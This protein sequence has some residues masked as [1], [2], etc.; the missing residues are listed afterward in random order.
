[1]DFNFNVSTLTLTEKKEILQTLL[2]LDDYSKISNKEFSKRVA[3]MIDF[4]QDA[5]S[6]E[7]IEKGI[8]LL[9]LFLKTDL[10][11]YQKAES[12]YFLGNAFSVKKTL[13]SNETGIASPWNNHDIEKQIL[14]YRLALKYNSIALKNCNGTTNGGKKLS[15]TRYCQICTNLGNLMDHIGRFI[16]GI[17]YRNAALSQNKKFGMAH[18]CKGIS[19]LYYSQYLD[20]KNDQAIFRHSAYQL[21]QTALMSEI[22]YD[23]SGSIQNA[24]KYIE[25]RVKNKNILTQKLDLLPFSSD[26]S[27]DETKYQAWCL[28]NRLYLNSLNELG[29]IKIAAE[30]NLAIPCGEMRVDDGINCH[31]LFNQ[32]K[33]D[34][35]VARYL[36]Y[37]GITGKSEDFVEKNVIYSET[38]DVPVYSI[39]S[40]K[41]KVSFRLAYSILDKIAFFLNYYLKLGVKER[42][43]NFRTLWYSQNKRKGD[44][45]TI[46]IR[47]DLLNKK[48]NLALLGLFWLS[49]DLYEKDSGFI[50]A[51]EPDAKEWYE[52]RN[53]LEH[54]FLKMTYFDPKG[55]SLYSLIDQINS[56]LMYSIPIDD[57]Q[58]KTIKLLK[59]VRAGIIY[60]MLAIS[61]EE[62]KRKTTF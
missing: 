53:H 48:I 3:L 46:H 1:M 23:A 44:H 7:G 27:S 62:S 17:E 41:M 47:P 20:N 28:E 31:A 13:E 61:F 56:P 22:E 9:D 6:M 25:S 35:I 54:K 4:S 12:H 51:I 50:D 39:H 45:R 33:Q 16:D 55:D 14:N 15:V 52:I 36:Y 11:S 43:I 49:K 38:F 19:Y 30:D 58:R 34:F 24:I 2:Q 5:K 21:L 59:T 60:L 29:A 40:E 37:E 26:N 57:F 32:I 8:K 18:G 10:S 42:E